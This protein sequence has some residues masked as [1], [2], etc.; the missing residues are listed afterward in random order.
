MKR[1]IIVLLAVVGAAAVPAQASA[2]TVTVAHVTAIVRKG[3]SQQIRTRTRLAGFKFIGTTVK[4]ASTG[5]NLWTC[6]GTYT[7]EEKG[8]HLKYGQY[9]SVNANGWKANGNGTFLKQW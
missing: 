8:T 1:R 5:H 7:I 2:A 4:C 9:I 3:Y 6:Y